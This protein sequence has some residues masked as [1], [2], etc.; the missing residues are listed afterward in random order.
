[1]S[2]CRK[3]DKQRAFAL[4][5][6]RLKYLDMNRIDLIPAT[7]IACCVLHNVC[8]DSGDNFLNEYVNEGMNDVQNEREE[9]TGMKDREIANSRRN[10]EN[11][12]ETSNNI[13]YVC[14]CVCVCVCVYIY[15]YIYICKIGQ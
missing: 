9:I 3:L 13:M 14:V 11:Y 2:Q 8:I 15:I 12:I 5:F 10:V 4:L 1:M 6:R 7:V